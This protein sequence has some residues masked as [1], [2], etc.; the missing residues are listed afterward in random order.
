M[1]KFWNKP[2]HSICMVPHFVIV[3]KFSVALKW[4]S[5]QIVWINLIHFK[6][7]P[8]VDPIKLFW[9][10]CT[11][12]FLQAGPFHC[13]TLFLPLHK[14]GLAY[15]ASK[16]TP[17]FLHKISSWGLSNKIFTAIIWLFTSVMLFTSVFH[18]L[19]TLPPSLILPAT[20]GTCLH[21][22]TF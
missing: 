13:C 19:L 12:L 17:E 14:N 20:L 11:Q 8:G 10:K 4:S 3:N 9:R 15:R 1:K 21:H 16:I 22:R 18:H 6:I 2:T 5:L 7:A